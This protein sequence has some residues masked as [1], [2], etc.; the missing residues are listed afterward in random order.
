MSKRKLTNKKEEQRK[1]AQKRSVERLVNDEVFSDI[2]ID[3]AKSKFLLSQE[4]RGNSKQTIAFYERF[5]KKFYAFLAKMNLDEKASV[6]WLTA[7][8]TQLAFV[9]SLGNVNQQTINAYLRGFRAFGNYCEESGMIDGFHCPIKEVEPPAKAVYSDKELSKLL[10]KPDIRDFTSFRDFTIINLLLAT[11][12]RT[13]T[14]LNIRIRDVELDEGY[15]TYN[16]TKAHKVVRLG[17]ERKC[18]TILTEYINYWRNVNDGDIEEDD[19]LFCNIYGE[20]LSRG[21]LSTTIASYN[22]EHGVEK[23]SIH[24]FRHTFAKNWITS[25][26]DIITLSRVLTHSELDMVKRY[27]NL[28]GYDV[29]AEIEEH[30]TLSRL[31]THSGQTIETKKKGSGQG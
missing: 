4:E 23:T 26:G 28:Y 12:A 9:N 27:S 20:Q 14:I 13:N 24:L 2:S 3:F 16:T 18:K 8:P 1:Q 7:E 21:G 22:K 31:R 15:I 25:G 5:F 6:S 17:L 19:Y 30:S 10:V 29:K 11:G